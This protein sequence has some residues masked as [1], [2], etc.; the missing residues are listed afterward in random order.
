MV[1]MEEDKTALILHRQAYEE[2]TTHPSRGREFEPR[3]GKNL[4]QKTY[5]NTV[6]T[7]AYIYVEYCNS[8]REICR[9]NEGKK[10]SYPLKIRQEVV[11]TF[12]RL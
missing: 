6:I 5:S 1:A 12:G 4:Q 3:T 9:K 11:H 8:M 10:Y 7:C 2:K